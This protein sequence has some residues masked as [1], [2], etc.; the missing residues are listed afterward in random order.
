MNGTLALD[1][2]GWDDDWASLPSGELFNLRGLLWHGSTAT[3]GGPPPTVA[4]NMAWIPCGTFTM[5]SPDSEPARYSYE[6]PQTRVTLSQGFWMGKLLCDQVRQTAYDIHVYHGD[7]H[8]E[9]VYENA[10]AHGMHANSRSVMT[11][12][13][14]SGSIPSR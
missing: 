14:I 11:R 6:G 12:P 9:K 13:L 2:R 10:L 3:S 5:G 4:G 1:L 7:G 8:L